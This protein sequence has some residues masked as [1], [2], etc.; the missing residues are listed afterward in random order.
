MA[1]HSSTVRGRLRAGAGVVR[2]NG[3]ALLAVGAL[4]GLAAGERAPRRSPAAVSRDG[5]RQRSGPSRL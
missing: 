5:G 3:V 4:V 2:D 1:D